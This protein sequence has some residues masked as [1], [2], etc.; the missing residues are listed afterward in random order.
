MSNG[1]RSAPEKEKP[2][3]CLFSI[4]SALLGIKPQQRLELPYCVTDSFL[5]DGELE[6]IYLLEKV[7]PQELAVVPKVRLADIFFVKTQRDHYKYFNKI[8]MKHVD[9]LIVR[10]PRWHPVFAVEL[11][12]SSHSRESRERRDLF[13]DNVFG[14]AGLPLL[15]IKLKK[16]YN[17]AQLRELLAPYLGSSPATSDTSQKSQLSDQ[18]Q[19][20]ICPKCKVPMVLRSA[21]HRNRPGESFYGCVNFPRCREI[22]PVATRPSDAEQ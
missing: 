20:P 16:A 15:R 18:D 11:D 3:G 14:S 19:V 6:F 1:Q 21:K 8:A 13:V 2:R 5:S 22:V 4:L 12:D 7:L 9:F 10:R 17:Q